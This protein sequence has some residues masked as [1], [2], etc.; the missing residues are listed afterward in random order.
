MDCPFATA[1]AGASAIP[2]QFERA[3]SDLGCPSYMSNR[4]TRRPRKHRYTLRPTRPNA[5]QIDN[6]VLST[7][8]CCTRKARCALGT[9]GHSENSRCLSPILFLCWNQLCLCCVESP[10]HDAH[11]VFP[12]LGVSI[13]TPG[14]IPDQLDIVSGNSSRRMGPHDHFDQ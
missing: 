14:V 2:T 3:K 11:A 6:A 12:V 13:W 8:L 9:L 10:P 4:P 7:R 1:I 5:A